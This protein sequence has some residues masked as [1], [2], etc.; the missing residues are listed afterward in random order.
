MLQQSMIQK[1]KRKKFSLRKLFYPKAS[2]VKIDGTR[3][4]LLALKKLATTREQK[5]I[6]K[7]IEHEIIP[8]VREA[9]I[10]YFLEKTKPSRYKKSN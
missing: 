10:D 3:I 1:K 9:W 6:L 2:Q 7:L 5:N 4:S 8:S